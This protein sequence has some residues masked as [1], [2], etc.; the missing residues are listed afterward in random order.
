M[1]RVTIRLR[2]CTWCGHMECPC[3][4]I[5][6]CDT[7]TGAGTD[8]FEMCACSPCTYDAPEDALGYQRLDAARARIGL[9]SGITTFADEPFVEVTARL[10]D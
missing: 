9:H 7:S 5:D 4:R 2:K 1:E 3:C 6:Y 8:D 10:T